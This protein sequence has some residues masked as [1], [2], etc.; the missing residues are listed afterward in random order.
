M[1]ETASELLFEVTDLKQWIYCPRVLYYRYRL[2][3]IRPTTDLI[4]AG[5]IWRSPCR[6]ARRQMPRRWS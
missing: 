6:I 3:E 5:W 1:T 4:A 2:P